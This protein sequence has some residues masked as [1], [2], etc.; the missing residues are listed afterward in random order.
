MTQS[1]DTA[2]TRPEMAALFVS[3]A[4]LHESL[5]KPILAF[6]SFLQ[7]HAVLAQQLY[8]LGDMFEYWAGDDD[9][10][11]A[12]PQQIITALRQVTSAGVTVFWIAGNR[13]LLVGEAF[14]QAA[15]LTILSDPY[16]AS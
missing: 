15:H 9:Q 11:S 5:P 8:L 3:D 4:H 2:V 14:A 16:I 1:I 6:L 10:A 12:Y 7:Q 13:D